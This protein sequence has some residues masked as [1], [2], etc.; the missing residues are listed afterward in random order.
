LRSLMGR[1]PAREGRSLLRRRPH[2]LADLRIAAACVGYVPEGRRIFA[3]LS[4]EEIQVRWSSAGRGR[5]SVS[6]SFSRAS[7]SAGKIAA[8]TF[9]RRAGE[10][11]PIGRA[12]VLNPRLLTSTSRLRLGAAKSWREVSVSAGLDEGRGQFSVLLSNRMPD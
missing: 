1:T 12:L 11:C 2:A 10:C 4:V 3:N 7:P 6:T 8:A 9:R 5:S